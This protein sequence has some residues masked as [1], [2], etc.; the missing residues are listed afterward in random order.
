MEINSI[1]LVGGTGFVG[2]AVA[3][4]ASPRGMR[5]RV[6]TRFEQHA[7]PVKVLPTVEIMLGNPY[8][9]ADLERAFDDMD[10]VVNCVGILHE[11]GRGRTFRDAHVELPRRI[12]QACRKEGVQHLVHV[13]ALGASPDG[14]SNYQRSKAAGEEALRQAAGILPWTL[15]RPS[16]I[17]GEGDRFLNMFAD[18]ARIFPVIPLGRANARM[19]PVWVDDVA[20]AIVA[21]LGDMRT[22][23]QTYELCGPRAYTLEELVRYAG[24]AVG[25]KPRIMPLSDSL[26]NLQAAVFEHLPGKVLTRDN[27]RSLSVDNVC[28]CPFP[29]IFGFKPTALEAVAPEYLSGQTPRARYARFRYFAGRQRWQR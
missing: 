5:V 18:L 11:G 22:F 4:L 7:A 6:L 3:D 10:A 16:I 17:F 2:R 19:Q 28:G 29:E 26:S 27:L 24:E 15:F 9:D 13:S 8:S 25:R 20:R 1:C 21:A 14:P 23:G 12:A